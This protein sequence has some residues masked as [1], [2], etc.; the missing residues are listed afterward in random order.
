[1]VGEVVVAHTQDDAQRSCRSIRP[2]TGCTEVLCEIV[3][4]T[5]WGSSCA[6][7]SN[8]VLGVDVFVDTKT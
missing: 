5:L 3:F 2:L 6:E 7:Y 8:V 1:M 4:N